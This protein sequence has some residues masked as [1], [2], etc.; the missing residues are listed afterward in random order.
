MAWVSRLLA[1]TIGVSITGVGAIGCDAA[2]PTET[3]RAGVGPSPLRRMSN[4]EYLNALHDLFP[5]VSPVL[6]ALPND[7]VV[8]GFENAAEAQQPSDLRIA[9]YET[10]AN[11]YAA[12]M[13][14]DTA[15]VK[16]VV[17]CDDWSTP[18]LAEG[19]A[20][21]LIERMGRRLFRRPI[22]LEERGRYA[23]RFQ[24]WRAAIDFEAAVRLTLS[25][26]L[27]A[28]SFLYRPEPWRSATNGASSS[29][30]SSSNSS[31]RVEPYAM[32]SR[33]SFFL[34]ESVPDEALLDAAAKDELA[35]ELQVRSQA[36]R[37]LADG[38]ARRTLWS[39]H[40]Q[41]L[42][43]GRILDEEH[44]F[45]TPQIDPRWSPTTP[46]SA[47]TESR[48]FVENVLAPK[49]TLRDLLTSR[50]AWVDA[51]MAR[52]YG[53]A[54]PTNTGGFAEVLLPE[55]QRAGLLTR[56]AFLAGLS[57]RGGTSPPIRGNGIELRLLCRLPLSP[58]PGADLSMPT[59]GPS[60]GPKTTRA[61]F[62]LRTAPGKCQ[63][64]HAGLNGLGFGFEH[65]DAAGAFRTQENGLP[66]D[67]H[68]ALFGTDVD[69]EFDG[70]LELSGALARSEV[71]GRC[72][73]TQW[74]RYA[75]G[76]APQDV[77]EPLLEALTTRFRASD[78]DVR[79]L[80]LAIVTSDTF[81]LR[82][83]E[84]R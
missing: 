68:G 65:Y 57:H 46:V 41:W 21:K 23:Q 61:L 13:T 42:G 72:A 51:D 17:G 71:V 34:W 70:A 59:A 63:S 16:A 76:R 52:I 67:A 1:C 84:T 18:D 36:E 38:R 9:R 27:Q 74:L 75:T 37:M 81:R 20:S 73:A 8:A 15:S 60:D 4:G 54:P 69:R 50:R 6:P 58:P 83:P 32:A 66:V 7:T 43:L 35:T 64:C 25:A 5:E 3:A 31:T 45:R 39:F 82:S 11:L 19:C 47:T 12:A 2:E 10:I 56:V 48:L 28:P 78:G 33:L 49:G 26:M 55:G 22:P 40:R 14:R 79:A 53:V 30:S 24:G 77:E 44:T 29:T 80:M 62:E